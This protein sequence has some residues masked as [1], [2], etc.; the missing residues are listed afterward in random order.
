[1]KHKRTPQESVLHE[2]A[3]QLR[4]VTEAHGPFASV[5]EAVSVDGR[6]HGFPELRQLWVC[7]QTGA[8]EW[9]SLPIVVEYPDEATP[10]L[11]APPL[12]TEP[13]DGG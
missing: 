3:N 10:L 11:G 1:M 8:Q 12:V 4:V 7:G 2:A 13:D 6:T 5:H 9:R